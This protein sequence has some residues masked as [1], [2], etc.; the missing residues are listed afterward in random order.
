MRAI[1]TA[2]LVLL[3][4]LASAPALASPGDP[5]LYSGGDVLVS[6][7]TSAT[8]NTGVIENYGRQVLVL[9]IK[10]TYTAAASAVATTCY[11][12]PEEDSSDEYPL[13]TVNSSGTTT[14]DTV[15]RN[16]SASD[17]WPVRFDVM[18]YPW[19]KCYFATTGGDAG[20]TIA[21]RGSY[22]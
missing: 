16:I 11:G 1:S 4:S 8:R 21:V 12:L 5:V 15:T 14:D 19:I 6:A 17:K 20:D 10:Y 13:Q 18:G 2:L 3:A 9:W 22:Q 7:D